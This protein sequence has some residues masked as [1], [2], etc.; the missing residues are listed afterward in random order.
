MTDIDLSAPDRE[1]KKG[2]AELLV[3]SVLEV[4]VQA[5]RLAT[6]VDHA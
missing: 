6:R 3:V 4:F 5:V 1:L 2:A